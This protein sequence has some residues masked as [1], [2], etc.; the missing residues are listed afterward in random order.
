MEEAQE[1][2]VE[3]G[4]QL[5]VIKA[6]QT[7]DRLA[8][9]YDDM[10][11]DKQHDPHHR[12][13]EH[14][15]RKVSRE[16]LSRL[17]TVGLAYEHK[18]RRSDVGTELPETKHIC[19]GH[20][21]ENDVEDATHPP[22]HLSGDQREDDAQHIEVKEKLKPQVVIDLSPFRIGECEI[23]AQY[24][25]DIHRDEKYA[26]LKQRQHEKPRYTTDGSHFLLFPIFLCKN[27]IIIPYRKV[28]H[29]IN[30]YICAKI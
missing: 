2:K 18:H 15:G 24:T 1:A 7:A 23:G 19:Y 4:A 25:Q 27:S 21:I 3:P 17:T 8:Q 13:G 9:P 14:I 22:S 30:L 20:A 26:I 16:E 28:K 5:A 11:Q 29:K 6:K 10:R 12:R